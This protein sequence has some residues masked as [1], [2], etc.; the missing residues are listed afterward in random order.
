M[1]KC[2]MLDEF[3]LSRALCRFRFSAQD[4]RIESGRYSKHPTNRADIICTR[5]HINEVTDEFISC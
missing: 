2:L 1:E 5:C 4:M 3:K